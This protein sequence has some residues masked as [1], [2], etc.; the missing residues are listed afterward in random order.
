MLKRFLFGGESL[1]PEQA[2]LI[3]KAFPQAKISSIG[4]ASVDGGHLGFARGR[5]DNGEHEVF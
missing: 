5:F 1:Y 4:Y 2:R 3:A